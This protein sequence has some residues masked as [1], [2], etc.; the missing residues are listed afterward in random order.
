MCDPCDPVRLS[1][2]TCVCEH[3][4]L[5]SARA[6]TS[7]VNRADEGPDRA[8]PVPNLKARLSRPVTMLVEGPDIC[9]A[10]VQMQGVG[11]NQGGDKQG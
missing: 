11:Q 1:P 9:Q 6:H 10:G 2:R 7:T 5:H 3:M 8:S 4:Q